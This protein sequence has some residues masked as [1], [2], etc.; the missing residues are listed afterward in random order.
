MAYWPGSAGHAIRC[1]RCSIPLYKPVVPVCV[2]TPSTSL[3]HR[4]GG[5]LAHTTQWTTQGKKQNVSDGVR[6]GT[7]PSAVLSSATSARRK[8]G[9]TVREW[10]MWE[11]LV[12]PASLQWPGSL[13]T[14]GPSCSHTA[15]GLHS[16]VPG[17]GMGSEQRG[18]GVG[19]GGQ[20]ADGY[21]LMGPRS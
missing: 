19:V 7:T 9:R 12:P 14:P 1:T 3:C 21:Q 2:G 15:T 16:G 11:G 8:W 5:F 4:S 13:P 18:P 10:V 6:K 17:F 20:A